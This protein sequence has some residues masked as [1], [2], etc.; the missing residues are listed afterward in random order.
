M[1]AKRVL[2]NILST[3]VGQIITIICGFIIPSIL[4]RQY[5]SNTYGLVASITQFLSYI[6]LLESGIGP[7]IKAALYKPIAKKDKKE[8]EQIL[9][10][11]EKFFKTISY[12]FILYIAILCIIFPFIM[13]KQFDIWFTISLVVIIS[14]ST[15]AEYYF[16]MTYKLYLQAEQRAYV[17]SNIQIVTTVMNAAMVIVLVQC[18]TSI[19]IVKLSTA[20]I[21]VL[22]P[23]WQN[24]YVKRKYNINLKNV[25]GNYK[26]KQKWDGFAQHIASVI[27]S[28]TDTAVLTI[29]C[30][31]KE[32]SVYSVYKLVI[33]GINGIVNSFL[34]GVD[35]LCG[36]M[37]AK[38]EKKQLNKFF[39]AYE[40]IYF[41]IITIIFTSTMLLILPFVS[42]YTK[43]ITDT[44]YYRPVFAYLIVLA[45]FISTV[46]L[47]YMKITYAAGHFKETK[48]G[49]WLEAISN[50]TISIILVTKLG[51]VGVAIGTL[52]AMS[53][54]TIEFMYHSSKYI[55]DRSILYTFKRLMIIALEIFL[56]ITLNNIIPKMNITSY[57]EWILYAIIIAVISI[58]IVLAINSMIYKKDLK[59]LINIIKTNIKNKKI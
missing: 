41:T 16:G 6:T 58:I 20:L 32:V 2:T 53:I 47:P 30:N 42:V 10:A 57:F 3:F 54:R 40:F 21:F 26:L 24:I 50:I 34:S 9:K 51:V 17:V 28:N 19:Q 55:L 13:N 22:R 14:I 37:L 12:I 4:I 48:K 31:V 35:S 27:H 1:R 43:G 49:A 33:N 44:S 11:S 25:N 46:R 29:F 18:G 45:E 15:F 38:N 5:G 56:I 59:V 39:L 36:D 8:I 52:I 23:I 7:V